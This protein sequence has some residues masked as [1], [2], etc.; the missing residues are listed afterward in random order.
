ML[1]APANISTSPILG[2]DVGLV[3]QPRG[4]NG[5]ITVD[6]FG[7]GSGGAVAS[8]SKGVDLAVES[9]RETVE[10]GEGMV[11]SRLGAASTNS[12]ANLFAEEAE[13]TNFLNEED[14]C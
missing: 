7:R 1:A 6:H 13:I 8:G 5:S 10:D 11:L 3:E 12:S 2:G 9:A 14:F 4:S